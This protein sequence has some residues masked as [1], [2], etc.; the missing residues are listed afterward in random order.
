MFDKSKILNEDK[1][2]KGLRLTRVTKYCFKA[3]H[4]HAHFLYY[5]RLV[6]SE[7]LRIAERWFTKIEIGERNELLFNILIFVS[8]G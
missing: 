6:K 5:I 4:N 3:D 1:Y 8:D 7:N 2:Q